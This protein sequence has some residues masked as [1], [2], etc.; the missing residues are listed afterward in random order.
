MLSPQH[1]RDDDAVA[2]MVVVGRCGRYAGGRDLSAGDLSEGDL[3]TGDLSAAEPGRG[4]DWAIA[5]GRSGGTRQLRL[6]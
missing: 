5:S 4:R 1:R 3:S 6:G 2:L